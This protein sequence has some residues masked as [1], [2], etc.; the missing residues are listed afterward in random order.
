MD[1]L[2]S[3]RFQTFS[4]GASKAAVH[5]LTR[6]LAANLT[7]EH[8][9]FNNIAPGPFPTWMLSTGVGFGGKTEDVDWEAVGQ[10]NPSAKNTTATP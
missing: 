5:H 7:D 6:F 3:A 9:N 8:I 4:Y 10:A 2:K 1:G